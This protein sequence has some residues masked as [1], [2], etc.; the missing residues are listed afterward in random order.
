V[1]DNI[2]QAK[3]GAGSYDLIICLGVLA[4]IEDPQRFVEKLLSL[5]KPGGSV[6]VEC[7]D[8]SHPSIIWGASSGAPKVCSAHPN[9]LLS[10]TQVQILLKFLCGSGLN[11]VVRS[12]IICLLPAFAPFSARNFFTK[13]CARC[14]ARRLTIASLGGETNVSI[15]SGTAVRKTHCLIM[16]KAELGLETRADGPDQDGSKR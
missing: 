9:F 16:P 2:M 6:V 5:L 10:C 15:I 14:T 3:L 8:S 1:N 11:C 13:R 4:Y 12:D 7:T